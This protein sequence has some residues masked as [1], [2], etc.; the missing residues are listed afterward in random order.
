MVSST[1]LDD[2]KRVSMEQALAEAANLALLIHHPRGAQAIPLW[3]GRTVVVGREP[4]GSEDDFVEIPD[5]SVSKRHARFFAGEGRVLVRDLGST[6]GTRVGT[7]L[8]QGG[9]PVRIEVGTTMFL[10]KVFAALVVASCD[11]ASLDDDAA[12]A[13]SL[14]PVAASGPMKALIEDIRPIEPVSS[15]VL[16]LGETGTG[17]EVLAHFI[18]RTSRRRNARFVAV[19]CGAIPAALAE[20]ELFGHVKGAFTGAIDRRGVF[21]VASGGTLFLDEIGDLPLDLQV[22][23][24]R[25]LQE[26][27]VRRVGSNED[28]P[29]DV[30][31]VSAT[32]RDLSKMVAKGGFREDLYYRINIIDFH[33]PPLRDRRDDIPPL[34]RRLLRTLSQKAGRTIGAID[35]AAMAALVRHDWPGNV[36]ELGNVIEKAVAFARGDTLREED[37]RLGAARSIPPP[38][39]PAPSRSPRRAP[40]KDAVLGALAAHKDM[41]AAAHELGIKIRRMEQL[42]KEYEIKLEK[43]WHA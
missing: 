39:V 3:P 24:L 29:V 11:A 35:A 6:N 5:D 8:L 31:L 33:I 14:S 18:H 12:A 36:R 22:K 42:I 27:V 28:R 40:T 34:A 43:H 4:D 19:N 25:V 2:T 21:E 30:R 13:S 41:E 17:K 10:G 26:G 32:H 9:D 20:S 1:Q 37:L 7:T 38:S 16:L 15:P 23:L